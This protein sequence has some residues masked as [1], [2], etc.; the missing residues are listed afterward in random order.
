MI[1]SKRDPLTIASDGIGYSTSSTTI[2]AE[3]IGAATVVP[4]CLVGVASHTRGAKWP[5][6][7]LSSVVGYVSVVTTLVI[8]SPTT[9]V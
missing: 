5:P 1:L 8:D 7:A 4:R 9:A 2:F 3:L 6:S